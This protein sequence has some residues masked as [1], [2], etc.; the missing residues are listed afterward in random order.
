MKE[1]VVVNMYF[2]FFDLKLIQEKMNK[3]QLGKNYSGFFAIIHKLQSY[4]QVPFKSALVG[5]KKWF[6]ILNK[7]VP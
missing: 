6:A 5:L 1:E 2:L 4:F 3:A 7:V